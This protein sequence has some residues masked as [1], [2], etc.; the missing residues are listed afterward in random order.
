MA[1]KAP[2]PQS[3][4][5]SIRDAVRFGEIDFSQHALDRMHERGLD[6]SDILLLLSNGEAAGKA[7]YD[8]KHCGFKYRIAGPTLDGDWATAIVCVPDRLVVY[9]ITVLGS[10]EAP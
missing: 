8:A 6:F 7:E 5:Q 10:G 2:D 3:V 1:E 9:V 4:V